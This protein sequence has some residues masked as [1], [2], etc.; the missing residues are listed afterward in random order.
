[1]TECVAIW[2]ESEVNRA[3]KRETCVIRICHI[4]LSE[5]SIHDDYRC[6]A[7]VASYR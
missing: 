1:M 5:A 6:Y 7:A 3:M 4:G 2:V